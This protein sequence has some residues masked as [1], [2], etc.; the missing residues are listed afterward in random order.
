MNEVPISAE[1]PSPNY[2]V[3]LMEGRMA[4]GSQCWTATHPQLP[5]C[6]G[7]GRTGRE[8]AESLDKS[9]V[10]W[11][12]AARRSGVHPPAT[13]SPLFYTTVFLP[14]PGATRATALAGAEMHI[15]RA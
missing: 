1:E 5:G 2:D 10:A 8:A 7:T 11:L 9:R 12:E 14:A 15:V 13:S 6:T 4:D 3:L